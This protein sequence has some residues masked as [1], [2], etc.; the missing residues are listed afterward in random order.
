M[1]GPRLRIDDQQVQL[2]VA[3]HRQRIEVARPDQAHHAVHDR[4][5]GVHHDAL[6]LPDADAGSEQPAVAAARRRPG[7][8][9]IVAARQQHAHLDAASGGR[10]EGLEHASRS[11]QVGVGDLQAA[12]RLGGQPGVEVGHAMRARLVGGDEHGRRPGDAARGGRR[13]RRRGLAGS[14]PHRLEGPLDVAG[15]GTAH[16][17][18]GV[19]P[20]AAAGLGRRPVVA[21]AQTADHRELAIHG[22]RLAVVAVA[23]AQPAPRRERGQRPEGPDRHAVATQHAG[24][25]SAAHERRAHGIVEHAH[26]DA[27]AGGRGQSLRESLPRRVA[28][29]DEVLEQDLPARGR[30]GLEHGGEGLRPV[31]EQLHARQRVGRRARHGRDP[32]HDIGPDEP[33]ERLGRR[34]RGRGIEHG[35]HHIARCGPPLYFI[36]S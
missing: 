8:R 33:G 34:G 15:H 17:Q 1:P 3:A 7:G 19:A 24:D 10:L 21:D 27:P 11:D 25:R 14:P 13:T 35:R 30:D 18:R 26:L 23:Q 2:V 36:G 22:E 28:G 12:S 16:E 6:P 31:A 9:V 32:V 4:G 29:E 5:L 20:A